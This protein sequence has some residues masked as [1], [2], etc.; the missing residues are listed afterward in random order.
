MSTMEQTDSRYRYSVAWLDC[1]GGRNGEH[2]S[3]LTRG[4]HAPSGAIPGRLRGRSREV[5]GDPRF[6]VPGS[7]PRRLV[8]RSSVR[9]FNEVW[10]RA[11]RESRGSL[12]PLAAFFHPLDG[13]ARWNLLYGPQGFVQYQFA[14]P[15][16]RGDVVEDAVD[17]IAVVGGALVPRRAE[18]LRTGDAGPTLLQPRGLDPRARLPARSA[19]PAGLAGPPRRRRRRLPVVASTW[20][21]TPGCDRSSSLS[22]TPGW[23]T[24]RGSAGGSIPRACSPPTSPAA[25]GSC[26][27]RRVRSS[28][29]GRRAR[30]DV[31]HRP[32]ARRAPG[33]GPRADPS[34]SPDATAARSSRRRRTFVTAWRRWAR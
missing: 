26:D 24:W 23:A 6:R 9:A 2:R 21:R 27:E 29:V 5:P 11:S 32:R 15:P 17:A 30:R 22:C 34:S 14:V 12:R 10:F 33:R 4:D 20:P 1:V 8:N 16:T 3:V 28:P 19:R 25:S 31:G 18:A 13:V 7:T